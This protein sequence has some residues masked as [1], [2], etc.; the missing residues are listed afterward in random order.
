MAYLNIGNSRYEIIN[1]KPSTDYCINVYGNGLNGYCVLTKQ[2]PGKNRDTLAI[3]TVNGM[4]YVNDPIKPM[5]KIT[6]RRQVHR[7]KG[8]WWR[9]AKFYNK[10]GQLICTV[11]LW[12]GWGYAEGTIDSSI[13][14][15]SITKC[16]L[17]YYQDT[18]SS[19]WCSIDCYVI[20]ING[21]SH[22]LFYGDGFKNHGDPN[23][24]WIG[25]GQPH[26]G[27]SGLSQNNFPMELRY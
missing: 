13:S 12:D 10:S 22:K 14:D 19:G 24:I 4:R 11:N 25:Y 20:D 27:H 2:K 26:N 8:N 9:W 21:Q 15:Q 17:Y 1:H 16:N 6:M 18:R 7:D 5:S 23:S 3:Q